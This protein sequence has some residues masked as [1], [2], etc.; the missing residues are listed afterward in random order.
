MR[1]LKMNDATAVTYDDVIFFR[2][3]ATITEV[4]EEV[5]HFYQ[6]RA[7]LNLQ[8]SDEQRRIMNEI[9]AQEYLISVADK[10]KIPQMEREET[11][12]LLEMYKKQRENLKKEGE[13]ID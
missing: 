8:Y 2:P 4:L 1:Y 13:W 5:Y 12:G 7:G 10:Y 9:D 3:D 11:K 6:N